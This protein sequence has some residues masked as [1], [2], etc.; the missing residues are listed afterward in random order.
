M[1][2]TIFLLLLLFSFLF[3]ST[4]RA[5]VYVNETWDIGTPHADWPC[6][7]APTGPCDSN[8][9]FRGWIPPVADYCNQASMAY[10][11]ETGVSTDKA[12]SGAK[13]FKMNR[14]YT[15][16]DNGTCDIQYPL[17]TPYPTKI[18]IRFYLYLTSEWVTFNTPATR[19]PYF[20]FLFTN[21]ALSG[22]GFR[23]NL[24]ARVPWTSPHICGYGQG[25]TT[26]YMFF[27]CQ[28]YN[29]ECTVD[30]PAGCYNLLDHLEEWQAVEFMMDAA[31]KKYSIWING[32]N[33]VN[34]VTVP[35]SQSNFTMIQF[36]QFASDCGGTGF[37][38]T[39]YVDDIIIGT[40]YIGPE[41]GAD[42]TPPPAPTGVAVS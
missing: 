9:S 11:A 20:H 28:N 42:T 37:N 15:S 12:H 29:N 4:G 7:K 8:L 21:S 18:Y 24:L 2:K 17:P 13:S 25:G 14:N 35:M 32:T 6:K 1:K 3:P 33:Y 26:P 22:T 10:W 23:V 38:T 5:I 27:N 34:N 39:Y 31:N 30:A 36:S 16:S 19:E 40:D 41:A